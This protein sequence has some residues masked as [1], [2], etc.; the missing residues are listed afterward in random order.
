MTKTE[1]GRESDEA[2]AR[3]VLANPSHYVGAV[4]RMAA[5]HEIRAAEDIVSASGT[6][7][8]A[9]GTRVDAGLQEKLAG[10]RLA[11]ASL[12]NSLAVA[13]GVTPALLAIDIARRTADDPW[14]QRLVARAGASAR[15][16]D[17]VS[18]LRIPR[19]VLVRLSAARDQRPT[20]YRH[21]LGVGA[22]S[23]YLAARAGLA[24]AQA[25]SVLLAALCHDLGELYTDPAMLETEHRVTDEERR[26]IYVHPVTGWMILDGL[27]GLRPEVGKAVLQ[28]HE[29]LD[30]SG[31]PRG[32]KDDEIGIGGRILAAA[33]V[34]E[35]IMRRFGDH[36]RLSALLRLNRRKYDSRVVDFLHDTI[37]PATPAGAAVECA[38]LARQMSAFA[39]LLET[40]GRL[41]A[42]ATL[43]QTAPGAFVSARMFNLRTVVVQS[44]FDPDSL[45]MSLQ[46]AAEDATIAA[47]LTAVFDEL[48]FQLAD[49]GREF[50]RRAPGWQGDADS[51]AAAALAEWRSRLTECIAT[52]G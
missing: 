43:A 19:Q 22:I 45:D 31:Y 41:R 36:G 32:A 29:R 17:D 38:R 12:E 37:A 4:A 24:P 28:H 11:P 30:G 8:V 13:D 47:E 50:D 51:T 20:L 3:A 21:L 18:R 35:V 15:L 42:A 7:L 5:S 40:W 34:S 27:Q 33:D 1:M 2:V 26:F 46:L 44:G 9:R 49:L 6:K 52:G 14:L 48:Q 16:Q 25:E 10:H 23:H 39:S